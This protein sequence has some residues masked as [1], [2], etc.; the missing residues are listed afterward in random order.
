LWRRDRQLQLSAGQLLE[1][2][3]NVIIETSRVAA[4]A[5]LRLARRARD[6]HRI[7]TVRHQVTRR[8]AELDAQVRMGKRRTVDNALCRIVVDEDAFE[9]AE[10]DVAVA[11]A[12]A[13]A[14]CRPC[15]LQRLLH[16]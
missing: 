14:T 2:C 7:S 12:F 6:G 1:H 8:D 4:A 3:K 9:L 16:P 5:E 15:P 10:E 11:D 13:E